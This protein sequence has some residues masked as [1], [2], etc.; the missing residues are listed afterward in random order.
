[1]LAFQS[2]ADLHDEK[3]W[4]KQL[5]IKGLIIST[6]IMAVLIIPYF[7]LIYLIP[8]VFNTIFGGVTTVW[9]FVMKNWWRALIAV[10][11]IAFLSNIRSFSDGKTPEQREREVTERRLLR[12]REEDERR[13]RERIA[14]L[15][16]NTYG[17]KD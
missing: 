8:G 9:E 11:V 15:N 10:A 17:K 4:D 16:Q 1:M 2:T 3:N 6:V 5:S 13:S 12:E 7:K 14:K